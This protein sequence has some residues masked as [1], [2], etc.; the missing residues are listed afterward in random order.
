MLSLGQVTDKQHGFLVNGEVEIVAQINVYET[1][2]ELDVSKDHDQV[3]T[4]MRIIKPYDVSVS[5]E[6]P[7]PDL[8]YV[9]GFRV[10]PSQV[11]N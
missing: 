3:K 10:L 8:V 11:R 6:F 2:R 4:F 5:T 1:D 7:K 9:N